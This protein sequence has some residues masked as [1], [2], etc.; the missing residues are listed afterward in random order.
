[1]RNAGSSGLWP[2]LAL[3]AVGST[4]VSMMGSSEVQGVPRACCFDNAD[5][6]F[7]NR[8]TCEDQMGG[9]SQAPGTNCSTV[10]C[11]LLCSG[12][13]APACGGECPDPA[14]TCEPAMLMG[15]DGGGAQLNGAGCE[16]L[17]GAC[18]FGGTGGLQRRSCD[19]TLNESTCEGEGGVYMGDGTNCSACDVLCGFSETPTCGGEC[20]P[21]SRCEFVELEY[22]SGGG[23]GGG[24]NGINVCECEPITGACCDPTTGECTELNQARCAE[25]N[26]SYQGDDTNCSEVTCPRD[27]GFAEAP[28][29]DGRCPEGRTCFP[30]PFLGQGQGAA[31]SGPDCQCYTPPG[32]ECI[33]EQADCQPGFVCDPLSETCCNRIC[34]GPGESCDNGICRVVAPAPAASHTGLLILL[35]L[36][37]GAGG[38]GLLRLKARRS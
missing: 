20:P 7:L 19:Q 16:C 31:A 24:N 14:Q 22:G 9:T 2:F 4:V 10:T 1:M 3:V 34:D 36:L 32:G 11:P 6:E 23:A 13:E 5:C 29:C 21:D 8:S 25:L 38:T 12:S 17:Y 27:C 33:P 18:C 28:E 37:I 15:T 30:I 35:A 26:R